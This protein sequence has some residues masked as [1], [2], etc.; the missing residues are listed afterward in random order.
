MPVRVPFCVGLKLTLTTQL[1]DGATG[2]LVEQDAATVLVPKSPLV[3]MPLMFSAAVPVF[4]RVTV[5]QQAV[6]PTRTLPHVSDV[7][8]SVTTGPPP[9]WV[10][11]RLSVVVCVMVPDTPLMVTVDVPVAAV[12]LAVR[13]NVL[14]V[15]VGFGENPAVTPFGNPEALKVTLPEKPPDGTTVM[16][17]VPLLPCAMLNAAGDA[18]RVKFGPA[19]PASALIRPVPFGLPQPVTRS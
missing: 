5:L 6:V 12:A 18:V 8:V 19:D 17:L 16:V 9:F 15:L 14:V 1:A 10:T 4:F 2:L 11:V 13:V 7:G 3:T